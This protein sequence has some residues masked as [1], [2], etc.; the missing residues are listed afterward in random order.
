MQVKKE[1]KSQSVTLLGKWHKRY[2]FQFEYI[3]NSKDEED[4]AVNEI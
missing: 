4:D 1:I 2:F 3:F